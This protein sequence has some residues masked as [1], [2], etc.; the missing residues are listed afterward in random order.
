MH[1]TGGMMGSGGMLMGWVF[2]IL[3]LTAIILLIV[4]LFKQIKGP[5]AVTQTE[6]PLDIL[7]KR[8]A[9]GEITNDQ[10]ADMKKAIE[11]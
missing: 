7:K 8:Y 1:G 6:S 4:W 2:M 9:K 10:Y 11:K 3:F 5:Q